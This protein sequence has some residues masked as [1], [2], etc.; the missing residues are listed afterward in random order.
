MYT[1]GYSFRPWTEAKAI[2]DGPLDPRVRARDRDATTASTSRSAS[3]TA[4]SAR[5]GRARTRAGPWRSTRRRGRGETVRFTC[6]FLFM[7]S[8]YYR[9][10]GGYTPEFPGAATV[11]GPDRPSAELARGPR[12]RR[13]ARGGDRLRR[14][15][16]DAGA[17]DGQDGRA[18]HHAAAL[19]DL[20]GGAA[21]GGRARQQAAQKLPAKLA[22]HLTRWRNVLFGMYFF[23]LCRRKPR[24]RQ[25][26]DPR[27]RA[28]WRSGRTTTSTRISRRRYNPW[29]QRLCLVPDGD[30]FKAIRDGR[31]SVVTDQIDTLHRDG[32]QAEVRQRARSRHR[33][34][35]DR[36]RCCRCWA[37]CEVSV[38]GRRS[39]SRKTLNY[40]G[41]MYRTC[42]T[43]PR[44]SATPTPRGR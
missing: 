36:P 6:N 31:A 15:R 42:R 25:A 29:D 35:R 23:Q 33:R 8:G 11:R 2:A 41:M 10:E 37:A 44:R 3:A 39:I 38:D 22:Y 7:C 27:R 20:R 18:R 21:G 43:W 4:S 1:L 30:L 17:G 19:A 28:R 24:A 12:L 26:I 32:H 34:H 16:G 9:Y 14:H 40:K 5:R 13:Q